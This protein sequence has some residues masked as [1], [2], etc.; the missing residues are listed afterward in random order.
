MCCDD[1]EAKT[2]CKIFLQWYVKNS[3]RW[4]VCLG[5]EEHEWKREV[6]AAITVTE[7][8]KCLVVEADATVLLRKRKEDRTHR[9]RWMLAFAE[10][11]KTG[12]VAEISRWIA[13]PLSR[14][15]DLT[16][17]QTFV[18]QAATAQDIALFL[19]TLW[20]RASDIPLTASTRIAFHT[21]M[22]VAGIG[23]FRNASILGLPY[24]HI[25]FAL[26]RDLDDP[27][28]TKLIAHILII[29]NKRRKGIR[30]NQ[31]D[32]IEFTITFVLGRF[33][34]LLSLLTARALA[35]D[36]FEV[37]YE[38]F[39]DLLNHPRL[40]RGSDYLPLPLKD[41]VL[42]RR[43]IPP[44]PLT[45]P[46]GILE[47]S[48]RNYILSHSSGMFQHSYQ[49]RRLGRD[50]GTIAFGQ[51]GGGS[52]DER[53]FEFLRNSSLG[54]DERAPVSPTAEDLA[55]FQRRRDI[56]R[57]RTELEGVT[58][59]AARNL[60]SHRIAGIV[61]SLSRQRVL[62]LRE[63]YFAEAD[64]RR[65][66]GLPTDDLAGAPTVSQTPDMRVG[67][68]MRLVGSGYGLGAMDR[69]PGLER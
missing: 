7:V 33:F 54:R 21:Y 27:A 29:Q 51:L 1:D 53:L 24:K 17:E 67:R 55:G 25:R 23:G 64:R 35:D 40:E 66:L 18:K 19:D 69:G 2:H 3:G 20:I 60:I 26:V 59:P 62:Q 5:P 41:D 61:K 10:K 65:G 11:D 9:K 63:T 16:L 32:K 15:F 48:L 31:D 56:Q 28:S 68:F 30:R 12:S 37:G 13:G 8:W 34:C 4:E 52:G 39:D 22:L 36:A 57:L 47:P 58:D 46:L 42:D 6:A 49:P 14:N 44:R 43:A 50:L 38:T 45:Q